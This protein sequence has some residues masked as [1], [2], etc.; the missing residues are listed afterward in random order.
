MRR[1]RPPAA[2]KDAGRDPLFRCASGH[3]GG[4]GGRECG[5]ASQR[6]AQQRAGIERRQVAR[7]HL[8]PLAQSRIVAGQHQTVDHSRRPPAGPT[9]GSKRPARPVSRDPDNGESAQAQRHRRPMRPR[10]GNAA[11]EEARDQDTG[12]DRDRPGRAACRLVPQRPRHHHRCNAC[13]HE[14]RARLEQ[15]DVRNQPPGN[16]QAAM[17]RNRRQAP[18]APS[19]AAGGFAPAERTPGWRTAARRCARGGRRPA[20]GTCPHPP[21][22]DRRAPGSP[23]LGAPAVNSCVA[24]T[25]PFSIRA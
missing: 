16:Q 8:A 6:L 10:S 15:C 17:W 24:S 21:T 4:G 14:A 5:A 3:E 9:G 1:Y 7:R 2:A 12:A 23:D 13:H 11:D 19:R 22:A 18:R 20:S 25:P